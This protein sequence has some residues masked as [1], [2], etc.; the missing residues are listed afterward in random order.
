MSEKIIPFEYEHQPVHFTADGWFNATEAAASYGKRPNDWLALP[1]TARYLDALCRKYEV[2]KSHFMKT[3]RG[4]DTRKSSNAQGTWL[5]PKLVVRFAQWLDV[6]FAVWCDEQIDALIQSTAPPDDWRK[7]RH[8]AGARFRGVCDMV[9]LS[10][11]AEGKGTAAHHY[12]NEAK[13]IN[14]ALTGHFAPLD[15]DALSAKELRLLELL[16][17]QDMV[18]IGRGVP[19]DERKQ[20]LLVFAAAQR[21]RLDLPANDARRLSA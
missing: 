9:N 6:D 16:E 11:M 7:A 1:E 12:A 4:G 18:L 5:H 13:L 8:D 20:A 3:R 2:G 19:Y 17:A 14:W 21:Q 15:R 10:R